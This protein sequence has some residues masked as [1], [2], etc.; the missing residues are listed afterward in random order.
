MTRHGEVLC[1]GARARRLGPA[2]PDLR[3]GTEGGG[4][5]LP[6]KTVPSS[7]VGGEV[8]LDFRTD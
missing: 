5:G 3:G 4:V 2:V 6:E 7:A 8:G 1:V